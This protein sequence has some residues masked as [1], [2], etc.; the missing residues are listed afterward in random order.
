MSMSDAQIKAAGITMDTSA[1]GVVRSALQ[2]PGEIRFNEDRTAHIVPRVAG[3]VDSVSA[4]LG[5][6]VKKGQVLAVISSSVVSET[7][8]VARCTATPRTGPDDL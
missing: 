5:E 4:N 1:P 3:V 7:R 2:F 6:V 8:G